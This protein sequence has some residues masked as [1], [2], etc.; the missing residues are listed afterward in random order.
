MG[1]F[2]E[3]ISTCA[4]HFKPDNDHGRVLLSAHGTGSRTL[5]RGWIAQLAGLAGGTV[6]L[7]SLAA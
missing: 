1:L 4:M 6:S 7:N 5:K 2:L 3:D